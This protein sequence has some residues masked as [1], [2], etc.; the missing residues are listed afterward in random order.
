[1]NPRDAYYHPAKNLL[2]SCILLESVKI[3]VCRNRVLNA[4]FSG[5]EAGFFILREENGLRVFAKMV[6]REV[7]KPKANKIIF[8]WIKLHIEELRTLC[9]LSIVL[10]L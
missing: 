7:L 3:E 10:E 5:Y 8:P 1:M 2:F 6:P 4:D 9:S